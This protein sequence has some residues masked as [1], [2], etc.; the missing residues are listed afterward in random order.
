MGDFVPGVRI[1][2]SPPGAGG[3]RGRYGQLR[4]GLADGQL[5]L[6]GKTRLEDLQAHTIQS[7]SR[8]EDIFWVEDYIAQAGQGAIADRSQERLG[9]TDVGVV[10]LRRLYQRELRNLVEGRP[11]KQWTS[12]AG[13]VARAHGSPV[14]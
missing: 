4:H 7:G 6:S 14:R 1:A 8:Y 12:S 11:L 13:A 3:R 10:L 5:V 9:S 2:T